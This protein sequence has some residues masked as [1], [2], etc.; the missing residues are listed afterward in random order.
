MRKLLV[1]LSLLVAQF[2]LA[3]VR[4]DEIVAR[5]NKTKHK[6]K[7]GVS[8]YRQIEAKPL[9]RT[10]YAG[11]YRPGGLDHMLTL[12]ANGGS[13]QDHHGTYTLRNLRID[14]A[15][16]TATK[17]YAN[18]TTGKL[19]GVFLRQI[20]REGTS[21]QNARVTSDSTGLGVVDLDFRISGINIDKLFY[22]GDML[23]R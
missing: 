15:H 20:V 22:E 5:F 16:L 19:E 14:G 1:I 10:S 23:M 3:G 8:Q 9:V 18:G 12:S 11:T 13:G 21:S 4:T 7:H 2:A 17:V 6:Q